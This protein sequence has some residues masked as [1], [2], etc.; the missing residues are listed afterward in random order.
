MQASR[1]KCLYASLV[2]PALLLLAAR[3]DADTLTVTSAPPGA[4]VE[5]DGV[6]VGITPYE[7][8]YPYSYFHKPH[9]A[10]GER[11][12]HAMVMRV[13]K[14]G[15]EAQHVA[16]TSGPLEWVGLTGHHHGKYFLLKYY[17]F[18]IKLV[19]ESDIADGNIEPR[20]REGPLLT[21]PPT[22]LPPTGPVVTS[23]SGM[24]QIESDPSR[25]DIYVDWKFAGQTPSTVRLAS[26]PHHLEVKLSGRKNWERELEVTMDSKLT[27]HPVL[28]PDP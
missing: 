12:H 20:G 28:E 17:R 24:V 27:L 13:Y 14:D 8:S 5:I 1:R 10:F 26:G 19:P 25:A 22:S 2:L 15:Y 21:H 16:M 23:G 6:V 4:T 11:L 7:T 3:T 18:D 9:T